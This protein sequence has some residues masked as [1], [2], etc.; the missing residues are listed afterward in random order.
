MVEQI[1]GVVQSSFADVLRRCLISVLPKP[2]PRSA[3]KLQRIRKGEGL[4]RKGRG[5]ALSAT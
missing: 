5:R 3:Q 2:E 4:G 1:S